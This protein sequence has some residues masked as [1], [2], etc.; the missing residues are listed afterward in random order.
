MQQPFHGS[1]HRKSQ[2]HV[3]AYKNY[4]VPRHCI[5]VLDKGALPK[6]FFFLDG[7]PSLMSSKFQTGLCLH[8]C[9]LPL[10]SI[11]MQ[12][13]HHLSIYICIY[14]NLYLCVYLHLL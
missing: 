14:V 13:G 6:G 3:A 10:C 12:E 11:D 7:Q 1:R 5:R 2:T 9:Y 8:P 4:R